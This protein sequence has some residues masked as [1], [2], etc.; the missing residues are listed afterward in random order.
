[1]AASGP[2]RYTVALRGFSDFE[3]SALAS[4]FRLAAGR[5]PGYTQIDSLDECDFVIADADQHDTVAAVEDADRAADTV[6]IGARPPAHAGAW[7][8]RPI[9]P[10]R[11]QRELDTL[12]ERRNAPSQPDTQPAELDG[13]RP[14]RDVLVVDDSRIA[15]KFLQLRLQR[16]GFRVHSARTGEQALD[17]LAAH[18]FAAVFLDIVLGPPGSLNGLSLCQ[19]IKQHPA[20]GEAAPAVVMVTGSSSESDRVR[21]ALAGCDAYL[22]KPLMDDELTAAVRALRLSGA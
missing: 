11:I 9:E 5:N 3:R 21:G 1:M 19:H 8:P 7:L 12:I 18:R 6:F 20:P 13:G 2:T 15:L 14:V 16:M 10:H 17:K 4:F 22:V